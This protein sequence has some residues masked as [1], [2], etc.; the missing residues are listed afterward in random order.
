MKVFY[1]NPTRLQGQIPCGFPI[2]LPDFQAGKPD[3]WLRT[4]ARVG[5]LLWHYCSTVCGSP[6]QQEGDLILAW[7]HLSY[8]LVVASSLSLDMGNL[9]LVSSNLLLSM[10]VQQLVAI[11][12]S[13]RRRW[14]HILLLHHLQLKISKYC[15]SIVSHYYYIITNILH[16]DLLYSCRLDLLYFK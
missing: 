6:N 7:L 9:S 15:F 2:L 14:S 8:C 16:R 10:G 3:M 4:F 12:C 1:S 11:S 5:E 13:H